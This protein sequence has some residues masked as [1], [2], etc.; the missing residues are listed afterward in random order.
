MNTR[1]QQAVCLIAGTVQVSSVSASNKHLR[2]LTGQCFEIG[3]K[4][5]PPKHWRQ[6]DNLK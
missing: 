5:I 4:N 6:L 2:N 3:N 1:R